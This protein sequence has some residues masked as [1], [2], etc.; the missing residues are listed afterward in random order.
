MGL[1]MAVRGDRTVSAPPQRGRQSNRGWD[2]GQSKFAARTA[3]SSPIPRSCPRPTGCPRS[4]N[5]Q[6]GA[7]RTYVNCIMNIRLNLYDASLEP[8]H[9]ARAVRLFGT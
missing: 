4:T 5:A 9:G 7:R 2:D 3:F 8:G 6:V 1:R